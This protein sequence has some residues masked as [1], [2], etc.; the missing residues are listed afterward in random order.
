MWTP[1]LDAKYPN[2]VVFT[3]EGFPD[4]SPYVKD[5][6]PPVVIEPNFSGDRYQDEKIANEAVGLE[7]TPEDRTWHHHEDGKTLLLIPTD[8]HKAVRHAGGVAIVNGLDQ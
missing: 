4:F 8:I 3:D 7:E 5:E 1:K 2:G 6:W